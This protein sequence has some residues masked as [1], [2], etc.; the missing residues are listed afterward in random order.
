[1]K[2]LNLFLAVAFLMVSCS[3]NTSTSTT[4]TTTTTTST[5]TAPTTKS[6][7]L[8]PADFEKKLNATEGAHLVDVRTPDEFGAGTIDKAA[9]IDFWGASFKDEIAK[10]D[11]DKTLFIFCKSGGRSGEAT[12]VCKELGFKEIYDLRGG[13]MAWQSYKQ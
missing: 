5:T 12:Q 10:L 8:A 6:E 11:K 2:V 13:Y 9:N 7:V 1:M 4:T 3:A